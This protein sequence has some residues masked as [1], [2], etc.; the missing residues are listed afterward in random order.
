MLRTIFYA[1]KGVDDMDELRKKIIH[2]SHCQL[3]TWKQIFSFLQYDSSLQHLYNYSPNDLQQILQVP[4]N[5]ACQVKKYLQTIPIQDILN[6]YE[7]QSIYCITIIDDE[8]P[9]LLKN[10]YDPPWVLFCKGDLSLFQ[11]K[12]C[13][14]VVGT[15]QPTQY[16]YDAIQSVLAPLLHNQFVIVSGLALG[17]D[18]AAHQLAIAKQ[19]KTI[20]VLG[21]GFYN[22][23]PKHNLP[24][25]NE[26]AHNHLLVS[27][28]PP[29]T[30]PAKWHFPKRNRIIS[31]LTSGTVVVQAKERSG[32]FITADQALQQG[33]EVFAIPGPITDDAS[34]GVNKLIQMGAKLVQNPTDIISELHRFQSH[35]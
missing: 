31:G 32:S 27:E 7:E 9:H 33:R 15:R 26:I 29:P 6:K 16:G 13:L 24:L 3:L 1:I 11:Y 34:K 23:Y 35:R 22:I 18:T 21:S 14:S 25:A 10:I 2:L 8:Y 30:K 20:A 19:A 28:Y 4:F 17:I 12:D 5:R